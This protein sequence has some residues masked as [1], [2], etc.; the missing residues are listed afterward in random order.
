MLDDEEIHV[1]HDTYESVSGN[2]AMETFRLHPFTHLA[3]HLV[4]S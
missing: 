1:L 2:S 4:C 3:E